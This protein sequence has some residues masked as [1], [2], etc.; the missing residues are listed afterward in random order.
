V[1]VKHLSVL[2]PCLTLLFASNL[3]AADC[4]AWRYS[5]TPYIWGVNI[6]GD[7]EVGVPAEG[8][9]NQLL[10]ISE[11]FSNIL[12]HVYFGGILDLDANKGKFGVFANVMFVN[13]KGLEVTTSDG[14][15]VL[16][17][18][19]FGLFSTGVSYR[20]LEHKINHH[21]TIGL[22]PYIGVRYTKNTSG[23]VLAEAPD[24]PEFGSTYEA[25]WTEPFIGAMLLFD[26]NQ[27]WSLNLAGDVGG[28]N[29]NQDSYDIIGLVRY[30]PIKCCIISLGYRQFYQSF[31]TG[32]G[33]TY[34]DWKMHIG[35]P[36]VGL[37]FRF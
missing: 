12:K 20:A 28:I 32:S 8:I 29:K 13:I 19:K 21:S 16:V 11:K 15:E 27:Y 6:D 24:D 10:H 4:D 5:V 33:P 26:I 23:A 7:I 18:T 34:F 17:D 30:K 25:H 1:R 3:Y 2:Y 22:E 31:T 14:F 37:T 9:P 36:I 35:G